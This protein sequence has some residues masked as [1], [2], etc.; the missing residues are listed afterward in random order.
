M[1]KNYFKAVGHQTITFDMQGRQVAV[2]DESAN[3]V[4]LSAKEIEAIYF[5]A[6]SMGWLNND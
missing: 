4:V 3:S 5:T 2:T 6:K 1:V